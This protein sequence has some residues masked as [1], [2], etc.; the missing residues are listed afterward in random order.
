M[1]SALDQVYQ[2][3][4]LSIIVT[5]DIVRLVQGCSV[6]RIGIIRHMHASIITGVRS[7]LYGSNQANITKVLTH[8]TSYNVDPQVS[9]PKVSVSN[10]YIA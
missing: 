3:S 7:I 10:L 8:S 4:Y 6:N 1:E 9:P 2:I 5:P